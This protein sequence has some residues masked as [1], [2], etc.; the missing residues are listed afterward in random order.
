MARKLN[1]IQAVFSHLA[2]LGLRVSGAV[3]SRLPPAAW[4]ALST[5]VAH[6][7]W[8]TMKVYRKR[9]IK[10]LLDMGRSPQEARRIGKASFRSNLLVLFESFAMSRIVARRGIQIENRISPEAEKVMERIRSGEEVFTIGVSGHTGV[11]ELL[12]AEFARLCAPTPVVISARLPKN[13]I[14]ADYLRNIRTG[15]G[16]HLVEKDEFVRYLMKKARNK[17]PRVYIFLGDQHV[18]RG[19]PVPFMGKPACTV[20][21][22]ATF[23]LKYGGPFMIGRSVRKAPGK[24]I[25][26]MDILDTGPFKEMAGEEASY[27][28]TARLNE[29]IEASINMAPEQ[30]S[31]GHRRWRK[32]CEA[33]AASRE[34]G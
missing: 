29:Y 24:Y 22:P 11:W 1:P 32:C 20:A 6:V 27:A 23:H 13:P 12:G 4:G 30:W 5:A 10:N 2:V 16:L 3:I 15:F 21:I 8:I 31:W 14:I 26:E 18:K 34:S 28:M 19:L 25:F 33:G 17:E 7:L 9:T